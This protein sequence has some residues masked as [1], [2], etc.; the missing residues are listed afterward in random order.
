[1]TQFQIWKMTHEKLPAEQ[2][3]AICSGK[4]A[5]LL[6]NEKV[7][8]LKFKI[9]KKTKNSIRYELS[10]QPH[11]HITLDT[12]EHAVV[13]TATNIPDAEEVF[14]EFYSMLQRENF[15]LIT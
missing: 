8:G 5:E 2:Q 13:F 10:G 3:Y 9:H 15:T 14:A 6:Q 12:A 4:V 7:A 1:M 11:H